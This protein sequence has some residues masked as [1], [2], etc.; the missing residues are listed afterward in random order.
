MNMQLQRSKY[1]R[2]M[3]NMQIYATSLLI[4]FTDSYRIEKYILLGLDYF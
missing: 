3:K 2:Y 1:A 4:I